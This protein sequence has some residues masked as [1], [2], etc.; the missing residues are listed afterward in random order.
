MPDAQTIEL[1]K[2]IKLNLNAQIGWFNS[3]NSL[4]HFTIFEFLE[5]DQNEVKFCNQLQRIASEIEP[6]DMICNEVD[7]FTNRDT[8]AFYIKPN[9]ISFVYMQNLM[10]Q[11]L[12]DVTLVKKDHLTTTPH[13]TIGRNLTKSQLKIAQ[14]MIQDID[15]SFAIN[16]LTLR[17]F[18]QQLKQYEVYKDFPLLGKPK[19]I[20]GSLF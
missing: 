16:N 18:N 6:F 7:S 9:E 19:E 3:K 20:Q 4:A 12:K 13:L 2:E 15:L 10:K 11:I 17:K 8:Y 5:E 14:K 1:L